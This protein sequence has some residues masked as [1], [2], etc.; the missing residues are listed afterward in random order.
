MRCKSRFIS[1]GIFSDGI[2]SVTSFRSSKM[3]SAKIKM[4]IQKH[5][6]F[7]LGVFSIFVVVLIPITVL[8]KVKGVIED[9]LNF[10]PS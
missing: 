9:S 3:N 6:N 7:F 2:Q 4:I 5:T 8:Q 10:R 1:V